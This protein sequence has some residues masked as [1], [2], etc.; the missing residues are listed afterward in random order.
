M[1]HLANATLAGRNEWP[2]SSNDPPVILGRY[3]HGVLHTHGEVCT[4]RRR[5]RQATSSPES[6]TP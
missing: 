3:M 2:V 5:F 4:R 1:T 6:P